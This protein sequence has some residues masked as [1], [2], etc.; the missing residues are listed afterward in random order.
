MFLLNQGIDGLTYPLGSEGD[1]TPGRLG[2][3]AALAGLVRGTKLD[4]SVMPH[5]SQPSTNPVWES[6]VVTAESDG[7][8]VFIDNDGQVWP[9]STVTRWWSGVP[10]TP[11]PR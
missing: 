4:Q 5:R 3:L 2:Y 11:S 10:T 9:T 1:T 8:V 7:G 6:M